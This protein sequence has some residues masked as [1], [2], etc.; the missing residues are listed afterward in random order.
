MTDGMLEMYFPF[1]KQKKQV[2]AIVGAGG[3]TT[4]MYALAHYYARQEAC[5]II[6]TTTHIK[7]PGGYPVAGNKKELLRQLAGSR[8]VVAGKDAPGDKLTQADS[9]GIADYQAA[10]DIVLAEA[11]GAKHFPCKVPAEN[12]PVIPKESSVVLGVAGL[13]AI[14]RPLQEVCFRKERAMELL[15]K[16]AEDFITEQ[17]LA[18]ILSSGWGTRK[19]VGDRAYYIA[20][21]KCDNERRRRQGERIQGML[22]KAGIYGSACISLI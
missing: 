14:G 11:D 6:T 16:Q 20:L 9:M 18:D 15:G 21:N 10:A 8:I 17:D 22:A 3:K 1:I 2:I 19:N 12:E 5:V 4:L 13:D 7:K